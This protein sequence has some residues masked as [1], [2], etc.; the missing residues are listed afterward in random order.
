MAG[1]VSVSFLAACSPD[2]SCDLKKDVDL[3]IS[4][5][6]DLAFTVG[7]T[8]KIMLSE[9]IDTSGTDLLEI[10]SVT[11]DYSIVKNIRG[12]WKSK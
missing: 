12:S 2:E 8:G 11:G 9:L 1:V 5:G 10:D 4:M 7:S 6:K 3:T